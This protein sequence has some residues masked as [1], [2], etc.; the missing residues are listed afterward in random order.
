[1]GFE[2]VDDE[3]PGEV[4]GQ[5]GAEDLAFGVGAVLGSPE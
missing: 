5:E 4:G 1:L 3:T 2:E